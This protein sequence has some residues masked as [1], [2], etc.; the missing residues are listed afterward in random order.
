VPSIANN[1]AANVAV[2]Y[3]NLNSADETNALAKVAS[4][5]RIVQASDDSSGLAIATRISSDVTTLAT[6]ATNVA[7]AGSMLETADGGASN[8]SDIVARMKS[9]A[10]EASSG[11]TNDSSRAYIQSEF[12]QL[13][14]EIDSIAE[15]TR[16]SS[17]S[18]LSGTAFTS[19]VSVMVGSSSS[20]TISIKIANLTVTS[21]GLT[22]LDV[23]TVSGATSALDVLDSAI[24]TVSGARAGLGALESRFNFSADSI[25][26]QSQNLTAADSAI[27]D[28]DIAA[29]QA[30]LSSAEVRTSAA[31][32][33]EAAANQMEQGL[34]KLLG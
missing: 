5:S 24:N 20:D 26:T 13:S 23:S 12:S 6:A 2:R 7:Q 9:L 8:I 27:K 3:L 33:A 16:Y 31:T 15:G 30:A 32:S 25:S 4:G 18:L 10:S 34:L 11:T 21:L 29:E 17:T 22:G 28:V 14:D 1:L 19:G